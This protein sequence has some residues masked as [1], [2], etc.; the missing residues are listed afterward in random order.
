[1]KRIKISFGGE[2]TIAKII[3]EE[4]KMETTYTKLD[5]TKNQRNNLEKLYENSPKTLELVKFDMHDYF[6]TSDEYRY[7]YPNSKIIKDV[8]KGEEPEC[9]TQACFLGRGPL[10][11]ILA[12]NNEDWE[13]YCER[14]FGIIRCS[15]AWFWLFGHNWKYVDN[16]LEGAR[17]RLRIAL[18]KGV[19][20][21]QEQ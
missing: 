15:S 11:G 18:D 9:G 20:D 12:N 3:D 17:K 7:I 19:P 5:I 10:C 2:I 14:Q 4:K 6:I 16:T 1:M 8:V 21:A 13:D